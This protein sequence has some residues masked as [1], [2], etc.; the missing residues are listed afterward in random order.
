MR[1]ETGLL[2]PYI[3]ATS[4]P[5]NKKLV[6]HLLNRTMFGAKTSDIS[7][8]LTLTP[9]EAVD[10]LFQNLPLPDP[11][12]AWVTETPNYGSNLNNGR[13]NMLRYWWMKLMYEQPVS[14]REKMVL[15]WHNHFTSEGV[16]VRIPQHMYI[17]CPGDR[18][19]GSAARAWPRASAGSRGYAGPR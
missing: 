18:P 17:Q 8:V 5:W 6:S 7:Y 15:F 4:R 12:G 13:M 1:S 19:A 2:N 3:P 9:S 14:F 16:T 11:P 10:L